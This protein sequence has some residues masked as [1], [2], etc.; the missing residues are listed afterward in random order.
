MGARIQRLCL[1]AWGV[2]IAGQSGTWAKSNPES[3]LE[4]VPPV[5][6][7]YAPAAKRGVDSFQAQF[8]SDEVQPT[9]EELEGASQW[10]LSLD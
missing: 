7:H 3:W 5:S 6:L 10:A 1:R 8:I 2:R 4:L 9:A